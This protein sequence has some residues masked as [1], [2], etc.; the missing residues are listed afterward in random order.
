MTWPMKLQNPSG[1][2]GNLD[3]FSVDNADNH[4]PCGTKLQQF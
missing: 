2:W 3:N 4:E 1:F